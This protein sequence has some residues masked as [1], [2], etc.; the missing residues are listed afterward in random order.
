MSKP[1]SGP[2]FAG[3]PHGCVHILRGAPRA[4]P[5]G[6]SVVD[7]EGQLLAQALSVEAAR[8]LVKADEGK[9]GLRAYVTATGVTVAGKGIN[10]R[11]NGKTAARKTTAG[12]TKADRLA[13]AREARE[14]RR[15]KFRSAAPKKNANEG[16]KGKK[17]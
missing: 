10:G 1:D 13:I 7:A 3:R 12:T 4:E 6:C 16:G 17:K 8:K 2:A 11:P 5:N 14:A 15:A 9:R